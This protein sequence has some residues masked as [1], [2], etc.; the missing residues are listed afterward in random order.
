MNSCRVLRLGSVPLG[1]PGIRVPANCPFVF[2]H[3][4]RKRTEILSH[5]GSIAIQQFRWIN[6]EELSWKIV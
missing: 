2:A 3:S 5:L 6:D 1:L 4:V